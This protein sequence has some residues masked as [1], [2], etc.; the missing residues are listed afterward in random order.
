MPRICE[1]RNELVKMQEH[2]LVYTITWVTYTTEWIGLFR[3]LVN[4]KAT[5]SIF[6]D[7][8]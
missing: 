2:G 3:K 1:S 6:D 8:S 5:V 7:I 4:T